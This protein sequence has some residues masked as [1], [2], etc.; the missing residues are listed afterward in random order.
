MVNKFKHV[1]SNILHKQSFYFIIT[2]FDAVSKDRGLLYWALRSLTWAELVNFHSLIS[3]EY[4]ICYDWFPR[5]S[6]EYQY[7]CL[8]LTLWKWDLSWLL[9]PG[10]QWQ[11]CEVWGESTSILSSQCQSAQSDELRAEWWLP[12]VPS[13]PAELEESETVSSVLSGRK[14]EESDA[15][16][17]PLHHSPMA[18]AG[19]TRWNMLHNQQSWV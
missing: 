13:P 1:Q 7:E 15:G 19:R 17:F 5:N 16:C 11:L 2:S 12:P 6:E 14:H 4:N 9:A 10:W 18:R 3:E 8:W